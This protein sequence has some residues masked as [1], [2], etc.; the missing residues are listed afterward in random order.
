MSES[1]QEARLLRGDWTV[2]SKSVAHS[3]D[4]R[5]HRGVAKHRDHRVAGHEMDEREGQRRDAQRDRNERDEAAEEVA[6]HLRALPAS[7]VIDTVAS[8]RKLPLGNG[9]KP[10][11]RRFITTTLSIHHNETY[12]RS[13][14]AIFC[15]CA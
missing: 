12:G 11:T 5:G 3:R 13:A 9:M 10:L 6:N 2:E 14:A 1:P 7:G 4:V 8:E 15:T